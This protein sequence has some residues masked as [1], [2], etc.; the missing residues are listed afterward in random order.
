MR[1]AMQT[2]PRFWA[3]L[4][5]LLLVACASV[6]DPAVRQALA[7]GGKLRVGV[8]AG[9][10]TSMVKDPATG[11]VRGV[12]V[13][14]GRELARRLGVPYEQVEYQRVAEVIDALKARAIDLAISN[15]TPDRRKDIDFTRPM[16]SIE[17][18]YLVPAGSA[19][20]R[21]EAID[22]PGVR[23][24]VSQGSTSLSTLTQL[25][26]NASIMQAPNLQTG[27]EMLS[28]RKLDAYATNKGI[29]YQMSDSLPGSHVLD[30]RWGVE[31]F[32]AGVP[33]GRDAGLAF[34]QKFVDDVSARG[35]VKRAAERAGLRGMVSSEAR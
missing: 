1:A 4:L 6:P 21:I 13:D 12:S 19:I 28:Q 14:I 2:N 33:K 8:Y 32:A 16:L 22:R 27:I 18:G 30:G 9:S 34:L 3:Q 31:E 35:L 5:P 20:T 29:L 24:G 23:V 17:I 11:E 7:P 10:P 15:A 26:K 25:L